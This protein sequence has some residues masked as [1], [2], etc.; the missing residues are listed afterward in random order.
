MASGERVKSWLKD[1]Y[2]LGLI[3]VLI[4]A[5]IVRTY[6]FVQTFEDAVATFTAVINVINGVLILIALVSLIVAFVNIMNTMYIQYA[7]ALLPITFFVMLA[8]IRKSNSQRI[9][10][11]MGS[12]MGW[13]NPNTSAKD[14]KGKT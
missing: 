5:F 10:A 13:P 12:K 1:R 7:R 11:T 6:F 8:I 3:A 4:A 14:S 9:K 2:N